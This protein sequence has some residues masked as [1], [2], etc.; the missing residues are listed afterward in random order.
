LKATSN[1]FQAFIKILFLS[2]F[3]LHI[4]AKKGDSIAYLANG[5]SLNEALEGMR[6]EGLPENIMVSNLFCN[7]DLYHELKPNNY[8]VCDPVFGKLSKEYPSIEAF[9]KRL[10]GETTWDLNFFIPRVCKRS[11]Q[12]I[13]EELNLSNP[14]INI[15][16]YNNVNFNGDHWFNYLL[17]K[18]RLGM[19]RPTTVAAPA[20]MQCINMGYSH[21][22][23]AGIDLNQ[24]QDIY[25]N[26]DNVMYLKVKHFYS[27]EPTLTPYYKNKKNNIAYS[28][29][30]MF[31][32]FHYFFYS[33]DIIAKFATTQKVEIVNYSKESFLDQFK[34]V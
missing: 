19:P 20:L 4:P 32:I 12:A 14:K 5:P 16:Y 22:K 18:W 21:I 23:I 9:Y 28:S 2:K 7:T 1:F 33:F 6:K 30:E 15:C 13:L 31:L 8:L 11:V 17:F 3:R 27:Q 25:L 24:H 29:S 10:Y 34:K 26:E